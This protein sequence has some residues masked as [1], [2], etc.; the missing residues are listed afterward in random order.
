M[1]VKILLFPIKLILRL[2]S[3]ILGAAIFCVAKV[4]TLVVGVLGF[5]CR[6]AGV[7]YVLGAIIVTF[8]YCSTDPA[9][10]ESA[11]AGLEWWH[12]LM[13]YGGAALVFFLP[14]VAALILGVIMGISEMF[15]SLGLRGKI[16]APAD[17]KYE[18]ADV[19]PMP[20]FDNND[21]PITRFSKIHADFT[22]ESAAFSGTFNALL[23]NNERTE[24]SEQAE[25]L[26]EEYNT[27]VDR[28][29]EAAEEANDSD[30]SAMR[31]ISADAKYQLNKLR[32]LHDRVRRLSRR[33][34]RITAAPEPRK[35][36]QSGFNPFAGVK[37]AADL[38]KR[39]AKL[40]QAYHPDVSGTESTE[41]MQYINAEYKRLQ[42]EFS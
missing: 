1:I 3:L 24:F 14:D 23:E 18:S 31:E 29:N 15:I 10:T 7:I 27:I 28:F 4:L 41:Q 12:V 2:A 37:N 21:Q 36:E 34:A 33:P 22:K 11:T 19:R 9:A 35:S 38:K 26:A 20:Q 42:K 8:S 16:I 13:A 30:G 17:E 25:E 6:V 32:D 39:Y 40:C 5:I